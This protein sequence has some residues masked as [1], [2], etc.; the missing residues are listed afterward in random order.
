MGTGLGNE[1]GISA[2]GYH[3]H[4][5]HFIN[6]DTTDILYYVREYDAMLHHF[7]FSSDRGLITFYHKIRANNSAQGETMTVSHKS[8]M[9]AEYDL[10]Y[11][12][13]ALTAQ[14]NFQDELGNL[15]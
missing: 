10:N 11:F 2:P 5:G 1:K 15:H 12:Q 13:R 8:L 14:Y 4:A 9:A 3:I 6:Y 7:W